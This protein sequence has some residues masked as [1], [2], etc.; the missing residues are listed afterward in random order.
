MGCNRI[1]LRV[2]RVGHHKVV[3]ERCFIPKFLKFDRLFDVMTSSITV[4]ILFTFYRRLYVFPYSNPYLLDQ[5]CLRVVDGDVRSKTSSSH[6]VD[7]IQ[8]LVIVDVT[9]GTLSPY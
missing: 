3:S 2:F 1:T 5:I 7:K 4:K 6:D 8:N 9:V